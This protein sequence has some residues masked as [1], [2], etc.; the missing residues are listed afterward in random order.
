[1][2]PR[3]QQGAA[4][5]TAIFLIVVIALVAATVALCHDHAAGQLRPIAR[6]DAGLLRRAR[7]AGPRDRL[8]GG[9]ERQRE[10]LPGHGADHAS[11]ISPPTSRHAT[12]SLYPRA[13][14]TTTSFT[15]TVSAFRGNRDAGTLVRRELEAVVTNQD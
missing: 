14:T 6:R 9:H 11:G 12:R 13:A 2:S 7:P 1:M 4:L 5:F 15:L 10:W 8:A 3:R